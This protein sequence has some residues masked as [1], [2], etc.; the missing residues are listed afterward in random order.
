MRTILL[1]LALSSVAHAQVGGGVTPGPGLPINNPNFT[2]T[3]SQGGF[4]AMSV[5]PPTGDTTNGFTLLGKNACLNVTNVGIG[6]HCVGF[7]AGGSGLQTSDGM[8]GGTGLSG[9]EDTFN[10]YAAGTQV[11]TGFFITATGHNAAGHE[12]DGTNSDYYGNDSGKW[13]LHNNKVGTYGNASGKFIWNAM[14]DNFIGTN[15]AI[16]NQIAPTVSGAANNGAGLIR[17]TLNTTTGL[18]TNDAVF[19]SSIGGTIEA[20]TNGTPWYINVIDGTHIDLQGS[21]FVNAYTSGGFVYDMPGGFTNQSV[22]GA[23][24]NGSGLVRLTVA[25]TVGMT[26]GNSVH[27]AG[28]TGTTEANG[29]WTATVIDF[30]CVSSCRVDLQG[31]T[32]TN[33][34]VSGGRITDLVGPSNVV[35][36]GYNIFSPN[37]TGANNSVTVLGAAAAASSV[38]LSLSS[39]FGS[40]VG[41]VTLG[42]TGGNSGIIL[43]GYDSTT[44]VASGS[45]QNSVGIGGNLKLANNSVQ[46]GFRAGFT[47]NITSS[48]VRDVLVGRGTGFSM[49]SPIQVTALG[50]S[51]GG[52]VCTT[53]A[54]VLLLGTSSN[55]D[56]G[57]GGEANAIHI[58]AGAA[59]IISASGTGTP[60]TSVTKVAGTLNVVGAIQTNGTAG[61][62]SKTCAA[63]AATLTIVNGLITA[64]SGC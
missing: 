64:T 48:A 41:S 1:L 35:A 47:N 32:F 17:L 22:S 14:Q 30:D 38:S 45:T 34:Y 26:T 63:A 59:D 54:N 56:C 20:N 12:V 55:T 52:S 53:A 19:V 62:A 21:S 3:L 16:G 15:A 44:D 23:A 49:T 40:G 4:P 46:I 36:L 39:I 43:E 11:T 37:M 18:T 51:V 61:L 33:A 29:N 57:S 25:N 27:V 50:D 13:G 8:G 6:V 60:S 31:S 24:N 2:G 7:W 58:G 9:N 42:S 10:G 28:V 5:L